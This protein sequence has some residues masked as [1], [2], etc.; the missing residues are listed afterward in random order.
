MIFCSVVLIGLGV[1]AF[2]IISVDPY[3]HYHKPKTDKY[4]YTLDNPRSMNNGIIKHFDYDAMILGTSMTE[5]YKTTEFDELFGVNS[6]KVPLAGG[7]YKELDDQLETALLYNP[8]L[9][10]VL[11]NL[12]LVHLIEDPAKIRD[13]LGDAPEYLY[14]DNIFNDYK[15]WFNMVYFSRVLQMKASAK[16]EGKTGI[17]S[18]DD[19]ANWM[20]GC[21]FGVNTVYAKL[22]G[23]PPAVGEPQH[24]S[25][26]EILLVKE[27][28]RQNLIALPAAYPDITFY[29]CISPFSA[30]WWQEENANGE[31]CKYIEAQEIAFEE[32]LRCGNIKLFSFSNM[33]EFTSDLNNYKDKTH[34][35]DW[36]NS[37]LL[38]WMAE[39]RGLLTLDN[40]KE[41]LAEELEIYRNFDYESMLSQVDYEDDRIAAAMTY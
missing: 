4:Y 6:I 33:I 5:N 14:D 20:E 12:D 36:V 2:E 9:K 25:E 21:S 1:I 19:Y 10:I 26:D 7:T 39:G 37:M 23:F 11:R 31:I 13:D 29:Y 28:V 34:Y 22:E 24:L 30:A 38:Q 8:E 27:N 40:Y 35:G 32:I 41:Y 17:S 3:M 16:S 15:Y 18:F